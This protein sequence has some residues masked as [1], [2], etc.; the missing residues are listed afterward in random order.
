VTTH[1]AP[2]RDISDADFETAVIRRSHEVP[3]VVDFW[4]EWCGPCRQLGPVL[5][6]LAVEAGGA[7]DLVK[8]NVDQNPRTATQYRVQSI[9]AV[10]GFRDGAMVAEFLGAVP[11]AQVRSFLAKLLPSE[12]DRLA[13]EGAELEASGYAATAEDRYRDALA[14]DANHAKA[15]VGLARVLAGR[16]ATDEAISL[17]NRRPA[18]PEVQKVRAE[19]NLKQAGDGVELA[20]LRSR[21]QADPKDAAAQYDLGRALAAAGEYEPALEHLLETVKL[22]RSLDNDGARKAM[23]DIFALLGDDDERTQQ[24][25]RM[26]G[27]V[28]F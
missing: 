9:P 3:V 4:A 18:D 26:L 6:R 2:V 15:I 13:S 14:L 16:D 28:L 7:W 19:I 27:T 5:E 8:V 21:V 17:L 22:D 25:R 23:L 24:Y 1:N 12:A 11:E 20:G 10:K